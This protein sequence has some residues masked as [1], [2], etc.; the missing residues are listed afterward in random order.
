MEALERE[1]STLRG[2]GGTGGAGGSGAGGSASAPRATNDTANA[3]R[4][5]D[6]QPVTVVT[7]EFDGRV[8]DVTPQHI[9]VVDVTDGTVS[10]LAIDDQTR[11]FKGS[12][13]KQIPLKQISEGARVQTSFAYVDGVE[14]A[15][16]I[17]VQS[18]P[19][20]SQK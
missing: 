17:V 4:D 20:K 8:R 12:T 6:T 14:R 9:D 1:V 5:D 16:D 10:R 18:S 2:T 3:S 7:V 15:R 19:R 11:A 13:R